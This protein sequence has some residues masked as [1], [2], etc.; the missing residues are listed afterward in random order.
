MTTPRQLPEFKMALASEEP[1]IRAIDTFAY[2]NVQRAPDA[3]P[4]CALKPKNVEELQKILKLANQYKI[5]LVIS[6]GRTGLVY[7]Q[8]AYNGEAVLDL[9][10]FNKVHSITFKD[11]SVCNFTIPVIEAGSPDIDLVEHWKAELSNYLSSKGLDT[12]EEIREYSEGAKIK[13]ETGVTIYNLNQVLSGLFISVPMDSGAANKFGSSATVG[14]FVANASHGADG[15]SNGTGAEQ[16]ANVTAISGNSKHIKVFHGN[17]MRTEAREDETKPILNSAELQYGV[18]TAF[19]AQ[20]KPWII[21]EVEFNTKPVPEQRYVFYVAVDS[22]EEANQLRKDIQQNYPENLRQ[23]EILD[24]DTTNLIKNFSPNGYCTPCGKN[25]RGEIASPYIVLVDVTSPQKAEAE[26][27]F[28]KFYDYFDQKYPDTTDKYNGAVIIGDTITPDFTMQESFRKLRHSIVEAGDA[29]VTEKRSKGNKEGKYKQEYDACVPLEKFDQFVDTLRENILSFG[30][31][32]NI[33]V[34][35]ALYGHGGVGALHGYVLSDAD[36]KA[37]SLDGETLLSKLD[38]VYLDTVKQFQ[39]AYSAEHGVGQK[40]A[41][42][43]LKETPLDKVAEKIACMLQ[44]D[45]NNIVNP[46]SHGMDGALK[47][48]SSKFL[49]K[50]T[51]NKE[52][53]ELAEK[54]RMEIRKVCDKQDFEEA[55]GRLN[56]IEASLTEVTTRKKAG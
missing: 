8:G 35:V 17:G 12:E 26:D 5:P 41:H 48:I 47:L 43:W 23:F 25:E 7:D 45:E 21:T 19:G 39:G 53:R 52:E 38:K 14:A 46:K 28:I 37:K 18:D 4:S 24:R 54:L 40:W 27:L 20:G 56:E 1:V 36:L 42:I 32:H 44:Y 13:A 6:A 2:Q 11:D 55:L 33:N 51:G 22:A 34:S 31:K 16:A 30:D 50:S 10:A 49:Y 9:T 15:I 29:F 3:E